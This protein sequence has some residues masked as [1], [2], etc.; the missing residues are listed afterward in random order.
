M[1]LKN[2]TKEEGLEG[3]QVF[4]HGVTFYLYKRVGGVSFI[5]FGKYMSPGSPLLNLPQPQAFLNRA[6]SAEG[7]YSPQPRPFLVSTQS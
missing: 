3:L 5:L 1:S 4:G 2:P 6:D 7:E